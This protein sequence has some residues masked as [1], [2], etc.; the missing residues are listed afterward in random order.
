[1]KS[2]G[3]GTTSINYP[4]GQFVNQGIVRVEVGTL[5]LNNGSSF[6]A[7]G[8]GVF[9]IASAATLRFNQ[10]AY[11]FGAGSVVRG[12]GTLL[13]TSGS[14]RLG[15]GD[16]TGPTVIA[17]G[18]LAF[19]DTET[20]TELA[21][22]AISGSQFSGGRLGGGGVVNVNGLVTW[23]GG[24][25]GGGGGVFNL[26]GGV[27]A[28]GEATKYF[29]GGTL[30]NA[31]V[32]AWSGTGNLVIS[33][34]T[35]FNNLEGA[36]IDIQNDA[37]WTRSN[38]SFTFVNRGLVRKAAGEGTTTIDI[39]FGPFNNDGEFRVEAGTLYVRNQGTSTDAGEW[40]VEDGA[41][42]RFNLHQRTFSEAAS[43]SGT[44][45]VEFA[46]GTIVNRGTVRPGL[47]VGTLTVQGNLPAPQAA[48]ALEIE[49]GEAEH[50]VLDV[51]NIANL[52]GVL[53]LA[54]ADGFEPTGDEAFTVVTALAVQGAFAEVVP[55]DGYVAE[56]TYG[57][58]D[59]TVRVVPVLACAEGL[60]P[61]EHTVALYKFDEP[62]PGTSFDASG[63]G[64]DAVDT[65]TEVTDGRF[66]SARRFNGT[67]DRIDM[68]VVRDSL[69]G[70]TAWTLEYVARS[71][72]GSQMPYLMNHACGNGWALRP[73]GSSVGYWIKTTGI[74]GNCP[75]FVQGSAVAELD[76]LWH[77][78][79][80][81]WDGDSLRAYRD[82]TLLGSE[83]ATGVF[84]QN[85]SSSF[86]AWIGHDDFSGAYHPG[87]ADDLRISDVARSGDEIYDTAVVLGFAEPP[88]ANEGGAPPARS[89]LHAPYPNPTSGR[90]T[91]AFDLAEAGPV[92][93]VIYDV[94][95]RTVA[96]LMDEERPA[97][98]YEATLD[99][100][101]WAAG[102]YLAR[103]HAGTLVDTRRVVVNR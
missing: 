69:Q 47:S 67:S 92:R 34:G 50:D 63:H 99:G 52:G 101:E 12:A 10:A 13:V 20:P 54:L 82:G 94:L 22:V 61:D 6:S 55:P 80:L 2:A 41:L 103:L 64:L 79:A 90:A 70:A 57:A 40:V 72:D 33:T 4:F 100:R 36:T 65:G 43:L 56:V 38:G 83:P 29:N 30:N 98:R 14:A 27:S 9:E 87:L 31:D 18:T 68:D 89:S 26:R 71:E 88:V 95:G 93:L 35:A 32:F 60:A 74:G 45:T 37:V 46:G 1:M 25:L 48:G 19:T 16:V 66:C 39:P 11:S 49:L 44:G 96:V 62:L 84:L 97:G 77:Y 102:L 51:T 5:M 7:S 78:Y 76:T 91:L 81:T 73:S 3:E 21:D 53:R 28:E 23:S 58:Q 59:V 75:W 85:Q 24:Y 42:L 8:D 17:G 15:R 86:R